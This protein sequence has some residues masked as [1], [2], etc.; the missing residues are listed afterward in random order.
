MCERNGHE[1]EVGREASRTFLD[2]APRRHPL[3]ALGAVLFAVA[4][5]LLAGAAKGELLPSADLALVSKTANVRH[6][7]VGQEV[8]FTIV[9]TNNG[10]QTADLNVVEDPGQIYPGEFPPSDFELVSEECD[11]GI[12]ADTPTCEYGLVQPGETVTTVAVMTVKATAGNYASNTACLYSLDA[13]SDPNPANDCLTTTV[14]VV[15]K[16]NH[17]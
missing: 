6:V 5:G 2:P 12:S 17:R 7:K 16:R 9:A 1:Q 13:I 4:V 14:K 10:P 8:T 15:G 3:L 11:L